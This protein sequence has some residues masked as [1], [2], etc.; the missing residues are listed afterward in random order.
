VSAAAGRTDGLA[1]AAGLFAGILAMGLLFPAIEGFYHSGARGV[2]TLPQLLRVA[3][4]TVLLGIVVMALAGFA[5]AER[6]EQ[7]A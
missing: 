2:W 7:R 3:P 6:L 5:A 4:G 1:V